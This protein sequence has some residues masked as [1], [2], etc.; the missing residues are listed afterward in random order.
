MTGTVSYF[1]G[2]A[3]LQG[4]GGPETYH[5]IDRETRVKSTSSGC[6]FVGFE[7]FVFPANNAAV[8]LWTN[9]FGY[10][11]GGYTGIYPTEHEAQE[12]IKA[13]DTINVSQ[14]D[15]YYEF[16]TEDISVQLDTLEFYRY[17]YYGKSLD[18]VIGKT[19][20]NECFIFQRLDLEESDDK[21]VY[22]VDIKNKRL[23]T[24]YFDYY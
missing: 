1:T 4:V 5:G 23:L 12:I 2:T 24:Q 15:D 17:R 7:P 10:Q 16:V 8:R 11:R 21:A 3:S 6:I 9:V 14:L 22:I 18:K 20:D 13:A 19:V